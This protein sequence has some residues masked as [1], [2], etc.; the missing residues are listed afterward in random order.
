M[1]SRVS[2]DVRDATCCLS[3][4]RSRES[5][6]GGGDDRQCPTP[7]QTME[8]GAPSTPTRAL[9]C[10]AAALATCLQCAS[11]SSPGVHVLSLPSVVLLECMPKQGW[12]HADCRTCLSLSRPFQGGK[13]TPL[14]DDR[15]RATGHSDR[16]FVVVLRR[17]KR[18]R[19]GK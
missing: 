15:T 14:A 12:V 11:L 2:P 16:I 18:P 5:E 13:K 4:Q 6:D 19:R 1:H 17:A 3:G 7:K 9:C 8:Q 10:D